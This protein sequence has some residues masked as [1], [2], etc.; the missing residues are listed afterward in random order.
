MFNLLIG[1]DSSACAT[2][3]I[4]DLQRAGLPTATAACVLVIADVWLP[5]VN[6]APAQSATEGMAPIGAST[7][8]RI[9]TIMTNAQNQAQEAAAQ[10][11]VFFPGWQVRTA[12]YADS[13]AWGI[14]KKAEEWQVDLVAVG[15]RGVS[16]L[17]RVLLGSVS[18]MVA[19][20][21]TRSVRI[22]RPSITKPGE[23]VR[24]LIGY[25]G[26]THA[27]AVIDAILARTWSAGSAARLLAC[28]DSFMT[29]VV[30]WALPEAR[31]QASEKPWPGSEDVNEWLAV[32]TNQAAERLRNAG[33]AAETRLR[34]GDPRKLL[35][36]AAADWSADCLF[37]GAR[38][39]G[40]FERFLLG[41]VST[42]VA[43]RAGCSVEI[44]RQ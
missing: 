9:Q 34:E 12:S 17:N 4:A 30:P 38:G 5:P 26:S 16:A 7:N 11:R 36:Q 39:L 44:V 1:Y 31:G 33:L 10:L 29:T 19:A 13:P 37:V 28:T 27:E 23:P 6:A 22:G 15:S 35:V 2:A 43:S 41:S 32:R 42:A 40:R 21:C 25:D 18:Q 24:L 8:Q 14:V 3:A 20:N